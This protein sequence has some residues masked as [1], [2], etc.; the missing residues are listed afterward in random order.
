MSNPNAAA[1][2]KRVII[3]LAVAEAVVIGIALFA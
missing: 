1:W 3:A 2:Q